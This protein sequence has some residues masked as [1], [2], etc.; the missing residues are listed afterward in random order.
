[1]LSP[2]SSWG[3]V[4]SSPP[5]R[6]F[7]SF[8]IF[9]K[10]VLMRLRSHPS[11]SAI[12]FFHALKVEVLYPSDNY[13]AQF[14]LHC[15]ISNSPATASHLSLLVFHLVTTLRVEGLPSHR[16]VLGPNSAELASKVHHA[17]HAPNFSLL[18]V[19]IPFSYYDIRVKDQADSSPTL[20]PPRFHTC[21]RPPT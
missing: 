2:Y 12:L 14:N 5:P 20:P 4:S 8:H 3:I 17:L 9:Q 1:M 11:I 7:G 15:L 16:S 21:V 10:H 6:V 18:L 13:P 19:C